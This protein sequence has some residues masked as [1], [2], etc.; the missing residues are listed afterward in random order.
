MSEPP[1]R[2]HASIDL[3]QPNSSHTMVI[4]MVGRDR[5]VLDVGCATGAVAQ[6]LRDRGCAVTGI[7]LDAQAA[8][9]ARPH[10]ERLVVGSVDELDLEAELG[11]ATFDAIILGDVLEHLADP[12][13]VLQR[14]TGLLAPEG[15]VVAS[16]PNVAHGAVRL[17]LL[18]GRFEYTDVGL[19][20]RTHLRF[21]TRRSLE[22]LFEDAGL[23]ILE[24]RRTRLGIFDTEVPLRREDVPTDAL[25]TVEADP[26]STTYQFVVRARPTR[27]APARRPDH[28]DVQA[29]RIRQLEDALSRAERDVAELAGGARGLVRWP[30]GSKQVGVW[31]LF[32]TEAPADALRLAVHRHELLRRL[33]DVTIR[34]F[35]PF[36]AGAGPLRDLE[37]IEPLGRASAERVADLAA[38]LDAIVVVGDLATD[39]GE[40]ARRY[41]DAAPSDDH[42]GLL[43]VRSQ[44]WPPDRPPLHFSA[45][46]ASIRATRLAETASI[47][48]FAD[49]DGVSTIDASVARTLRRA[50][51]A[52]T[53][54]PEVLHALGR[55]L[56]TD[57]LEGRRLTAL[58]PLGGPIPDRYVLVHGDASVR[59]G[60]PSVVA[61]LD[62][63]RRSSPE[64]VVLAVNLDGAE[65][66]GA[67]SAA[68]VEGGPGI[69]PLARPRTA[70]DAAAL[71]SG[72]SLVVSPAPWVH[73]ICTAYGR[74]WVDSRHPMPAD[75]LGREPSANAT[76]LR[77]LDEHFDALAERIAAAK[78][79]PLADAAPLHADRYEALTSALAAAV[80][81]DD[82]MRQA[83]REAAARAAVLQTRVTHLE[84][85]QASLTD[86]IEGLRGEIT[87]IRSSR[88]WRI[89]RAARRLAARTAPVTRVLRRP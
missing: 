55:A 51:I 68:I 86:D 35:A 47:G 81:R 13:S 24:I 29:Q 6:V 50:G 15:E 87:A 30:E 75:L 83:L 72:A 67:Y 31:G 57:R 34:P 4:E 7:E 3:D 63:L 17:A 66:E 48:A 80:G 52:A 10:L 26:D 54:V 1:H 19:L 39:P 46:A 82:D 14:L 77:R 25:A 64:V 5:R 70:E 32:D 88:T 42:P 41:G 89:V 36:G 28:E 12:V 33:G 84:A 44:S 71:L 2:Y 38:M 18:T 9:Q 22:H 85:Q 23:A 49:A 20:D 53:V 43:L 21:F 62:Q 60:V 27:F 40:L 74:P 65:G 56:P 58:V 11:R 8:E 69:L 73:A 61:A 79:R 59:D 78:P 16:I 45:I 76:S 37:P